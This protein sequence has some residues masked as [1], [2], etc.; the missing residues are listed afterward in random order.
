[1]CKISH[2]SRIS[3]RIKSLSFYLGPHE[4]LANLRKVFENGDCRSHA[5]LTSSTEQDRAT[6]AEITLNI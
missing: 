3:K 5:G 1:M 4:N 6:L 2:S